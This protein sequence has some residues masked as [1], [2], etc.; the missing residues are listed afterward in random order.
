[1]RTL[2]ILCTGPAR[3]SFCPAREACP[4]P[5]GNVSGLHIGPNPVIYTLCSKQ[6]APLA[7]LFRSLFFLAG[8]LS[9]F[10]ELLSCNAARKFH[11][12]HEAF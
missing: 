1:M 4:A 11:L 9:L 7:C 5:W 10:S 3:S 2:V 12:F 8:S 6:L